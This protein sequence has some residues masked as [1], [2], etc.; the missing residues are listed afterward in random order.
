[1][2]ITFDELKGLVSERALAG[3]TMLLNMGPQHPST[4]GV[5][6]LLLE[7]DGERV[8]SC[9]PD[10]GY[11]HTGIEKNCEAK[12]YTKVIPLTDRMDYLSPM[13][14][15]LGYVMAVEKLMDVDVPLRAQYIR[16]ILCE[17]Q[18][19]ASHLVWLGTHAIDLAAMSMLLYCFRER[20]II[21]DVFELVSG[22]RMM[23]SYFRVG[24]L[25]R[26]VPAGF[27]E[28]VR[29]F[30]TLFPSRVDE[31]EALLRNNPLW[32]ERTEGIG[33][34]AAQDALALGVT[35]P[36]LRGSGVNWD[37]RK[38]EPYSAYDHFK[39]DVPLGEHG[40]VYD[41]YWCRMQEFRESMKIVDQALK[42]LP[43]GPYITDNRKVAPPPKEE[44]A[45][46][47][48][49]LIHHFK[50]WTE[51]FSPPPGEVYVSVESPRGEFACYLNSDGSPKPRRVHF[52]APSFANL[53]ALPLMSKGALVAD[54]VAVIGSIDIVLGDIDR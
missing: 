37:I 42:K 17:L 26:D 6:R 14:N 50:L 4:H 30:L 25:W 44:L 20:E 23:T 40:D 9:V 11:L 54:V 53:S 5:L 38:T 52:R 48:E 46:S 27:E 28:A 10:I 35:G 21:L 2:D 19:I 12:T 22:Q 1:M 8:V 43:K 51:G 31:Y 18:R 45:W 47:M 39:F 15:N 3:D 16:V 24:G 7:L 32:R 34:I 36:S 33:V 41:R 49:S 13:S 29:Q